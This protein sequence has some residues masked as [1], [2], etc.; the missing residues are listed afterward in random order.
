MEEWLQNPLLD[1][2]CE[3]IERQM[4]LDAFV[5][6]ASGFVFRYPLCPHVEASALINVLNLNM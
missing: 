5:A 1:R 2:L 4:Q 6:P 3:V